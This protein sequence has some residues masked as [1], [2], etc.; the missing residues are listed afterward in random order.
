MVI[1]RK[2]AKKYKFW[3]I[4]Y[5]FFGKGHQKTFLRM[6]ILYS[7]DMFL[8]FFFVLAIYIFHHITIL[9]I[10]TIIVIP[11]VRIDN[12]LAIYTISCKIKK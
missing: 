7:L 1:Q 4:T 12:L 9:F 11:I 5:I 10:S 2:S 8:L 6:Q 3:Y